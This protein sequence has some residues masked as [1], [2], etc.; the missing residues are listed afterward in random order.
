MR[1]HG[2]DCLAQDN[3]D[4]WRAVVNAV[5]SLL[6]KYS[7]GNLAR[8]EPISFSRRPLLHAVSN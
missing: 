3:W 2:V 8:L 5:M 7:A 1:E 6:V 4:R